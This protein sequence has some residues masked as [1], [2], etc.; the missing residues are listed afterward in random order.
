MTLKATTMNTKHRKVIV[1]CNFT[2]EFTNFGLRF[3][4]W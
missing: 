3:K 4:E 1:L 2:K